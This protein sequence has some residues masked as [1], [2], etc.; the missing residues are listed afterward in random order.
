MRD[1]AQGVKPL[2]RISASHT[3]VQVPIHLPVKAERQQMTAQVEDPDRVPGS[4]LLPDPAL[5]WASGECTS[6][7]NIFLSKILKTTCQDSENMR[8][9]EEKNHHG[10]FSLHLAK[11]TT[12]IVS[13][14][15]SGHGHPPEQPPHVLIT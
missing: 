15:G 11:L 5:V 2:I 13:A 4:W 6:G 9:L 3:G 10:S 8:T 7:W 12:G 1:K 14:P